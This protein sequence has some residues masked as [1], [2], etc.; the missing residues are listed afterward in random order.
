MN[1][2]ERLPKFLHSW[3]DTE[4]PLARREGQ[5]LEALAF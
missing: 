3:L 4:V 2:P 1:M 5:T